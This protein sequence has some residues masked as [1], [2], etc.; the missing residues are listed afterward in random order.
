MPFK[1]S[2][3]FVLLI[4]VTLLFTACSI[5]IP[6]AARKK[7]EIGNM[8]Y[9]VIDIGSKKFDEL[10]TGDFQKWYDLNYRNGGV[11]NFSKDGTKYILI[12]AGER[13]TSG[14]K[15]KDVMLNGK[16]KEI[17]VTAK[18][19]GPKDGEAINQIITYPHILI[20]IGEDERKLS[21]AGVE[22]QDNSK[23]VE[24]KKDNGKLDEITKDGVLKVKLSGDS[25]DST[26]KEFKL[27]DKI[28]ESIKSMDL[29]KGMDIIFTYFLDE[30]EKPVVIEIS[31][32]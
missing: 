4:I 27:S 20:S 30:E 26:A 28:K 24:L 14:Y 3:I 12:G 23:K 22:L 7:Y 11:Y 21:C 19:Y 18:L 2:R 5:S 8:D 13:L 17:E 31:K 25:K 1:R 15:M 16:E 10:N 32:M 29:E 9:N 6:G